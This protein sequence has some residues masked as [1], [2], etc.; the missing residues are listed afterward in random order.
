MM[1]EWNET[2]VFDP[3]KKK[4]QIEF[5]V[6]HKSLFQ[7]EELIGNAI[8]IFQDLYSYNL[9]RHITLYDNG[10]AVGSLH[11]NLNLVKHKKDGGGDDNE[12]IDD[13]DEELVNSI[14]YRDNEISRQIVGSN[15][16]VHPE[17]VLHTQQQQHMLSSSVYLNTQANPQPR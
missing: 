8:F 2:F 10:Q 3:L 1:P 6:Y 14:D 15:K 13:V 9:R 11:I 7:N 17:Y 16:G 4:S 12:E 5:S